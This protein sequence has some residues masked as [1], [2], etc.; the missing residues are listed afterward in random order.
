MT[1]VITF[2]NFFNNTRVGQGRDLDVK[3]RFWNNDPDPNSGSGVKR[4]DNFSQCSFPN[5]DKVLRVDKGI[6]VDKE[7]K[8]DF[9]H[10]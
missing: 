2:W 7:I 4:V 1:H 6:W 3:S 9:I 10:F 5:W 8:P